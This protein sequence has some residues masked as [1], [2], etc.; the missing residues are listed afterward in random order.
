MDTPHLQQYV[1][2]KCHVKLSFDEYYSNTEFLHRWHTGQRD[3]DLAI[4]SNNMYHLVKNEIGLPESPLSQQVQQYN[5]YV[6]AAYQSGHYPPNVV[7]FDLTMTGFIWNDQVV[8]LNNTDDIF[9]IFKKAGNNLVVMMDDPIQA[10]IIMSL[11]LSQAKHGT[12]YAGEHISD[13]APLTVDD[14]NRLIQKTNVFVANNYT[15]FFTDKKFAFAYTWAS[16]SFNTATESS[17]YHLLI[18]PEM[19]YVATDMLANLD[20]RPATLCV[21]RALTE[22]K[23]A[24]MIQAYS[25]YISPYVDGESSNDKHFKAYYALFKHALPNV[26]FLNEPYSYKQY[27]R[28]QRTWELIRFEAN[29][30]VKI[31]KN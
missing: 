15:R 6:R 26:I 9:T 3:Y 28:L 19:S 30:N 21:A 31:T 4:F 16:A 20:N 10:R 18:H 8:Q 7:Y 22:P 29:D 5:P 11:G 17:H 23:A 27:D 12:N 13:L 14:F 2:Q 1:Q 24:R 25:H